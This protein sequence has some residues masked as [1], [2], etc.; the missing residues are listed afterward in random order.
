MQFKNFENN[1]LQRYDEPTFSD[2][3]RQS[4]PR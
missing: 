2:K 1:W 4:L 3:I